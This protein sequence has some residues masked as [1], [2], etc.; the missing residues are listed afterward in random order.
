M[1]TLRLF[2]IFVSLN[3]EI[4]DPK[5]EKGAFSCSAGAWETVQGLLLAGE[6]M[7]LVP[8]MP[9]EEHLAVPHPGGS[10]A[11]WV[12]AQLDKLFGLCCHQTPS[13]QGEGDEK[14][15]PQ[16]FLTSHR[17]HLDKALLVPGCYRVVTLVLLLWP[18]TRRW[19][20]LWCSCPCLRLSSLCLCPGRRLACRPP[21]LLPQ[22]LSAATSSAGF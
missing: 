7:G 15:I 2:S 9:M 8:E 16:V 1:C 4:N 5:E 19:S 22:T 13:L 21:P 17:P 14:G 20:T 6:W 3:L 10:G 11:C 18:S 12:P